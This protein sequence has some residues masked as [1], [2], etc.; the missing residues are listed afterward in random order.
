MPE[1]S[2]V[3]C[4]YRT[5]VGASA[6][7]I[8]RANFEFSIAP[9]GNNSPP[10]SIEGAAVWRGD[11]CLPPMRESPR[12]GPY[13]PVQVPMDLCSPL[14]LTLE[15]YRLKLPSLFWAH[16][17]AG[18]DR[19]IRRD[20][21]RPMHRAARDGAD[22]QNISNQ[23]F[24]TI[25]N[26]PQSALIVG[27]P[28]LA[29]VVA[30]RKAAHAQFA[31]QLKAQQSSL[32]QEVKFLRQ[33]KLIRPNQNLVLSTAA[34]ARSNGRLALRS[35]TRGRAG[36]DITFTFPTDTTVTGA[37]SVA[38]AAKL[39]QLANLLYPELRRSLARRAGPAT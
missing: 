36:N 24:R 30:V 37:W 27:V 12:P 3:L 32:Q 5:S 2:R 34:I 26:G 18:A 39:S 28:N 25:S 22:Y 6:P 10:V 1:L 8:G 23:R 31:A 4:V 11:L 14:R 15:D 21:G 33:H 29:D 35:V 20:R 7:K 38:D 19:S 13:R 9:P 16:D 17:G